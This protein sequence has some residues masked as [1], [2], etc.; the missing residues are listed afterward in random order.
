VLAAAK[1][2]VER[3]EQL[4]KERAA[5]KAADRERERGAARPSPFGAARPVPVGSPANGGGEGWRRG[6]A[7]APSV[8]TD[9]PGPAR[10]VPSAL[11]ASQGAQARSPTLPSPSPAAEAP[12]VGWRERER[13]AAKNAGRG[14]AES[15]PS[16]ARTPASGR[17]TPE[18]AASPRTPAAPAA[19]EDE[20]WTLPKAS[21][22][23]W[24]PR[25]RQ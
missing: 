16:G 12:K 22:N 5:R 19:T 8:Q 3:E 6:G 25:S 24:K 20:G 18:P 4:E 15:T 7:P 11:R 14:G 10:F 2:R 17:A 1:A 23:A 9:S 21:K 13:L